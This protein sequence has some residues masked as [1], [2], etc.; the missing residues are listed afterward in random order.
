MGYERERST[1]Y[2]KAIWTRCIMYTTHFAP[3]SAFN[4]LASQL[5]TR[6][7]SFLLTRSGT[8]FLQRSVSVS[9]LRPFTLPLQ[10]SARLLLARHFPGLPGI[11]ASLK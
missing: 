4:G 5:T 7:A 9:P 3:Y 1:E 10:P 6:I 2:L 11:F 8:L